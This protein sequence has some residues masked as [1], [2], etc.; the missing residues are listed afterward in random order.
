MFTRWIII[1]PDRERVNFLLVSYSSSEPF[2]PLNQ[3][4]A[5]SSFLP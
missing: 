5:L 2:Q 3:H 4:G 1:R